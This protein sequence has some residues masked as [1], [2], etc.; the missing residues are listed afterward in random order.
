[1]SG[2]LAKALASKIGDVKD[3]DALLT[4]MKSLLIL[5]LTDAPEPEL[6]DEDDI[7]MEGMKDRVTGRRK[8]S[9]LANELI[10]KPS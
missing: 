4:A 7:L 2:E 9:S 8:F 3:S 5:L 1:M 10:A 6:K